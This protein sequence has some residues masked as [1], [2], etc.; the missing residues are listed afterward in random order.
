MNAVRFSTGNGRFAGCLCAC[1]SC[2]DNDASLKARDFDPC[3]RGGRREVGA[4]EAGCAAGDENDEDCE[5]G[6][7]GGIVCLD[8]RI[9]GPSAAS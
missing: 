5:F 1:S 9:I 3:S 4:A 7:A 2:K 8:I 6:A